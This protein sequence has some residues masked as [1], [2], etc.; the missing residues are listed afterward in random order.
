MAQS[1]GNALH[2]EYVIQ[3][4]NMG[5]AMTDFEDEVLRLLKQILS[6]LR[7]AQKK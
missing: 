3:R 5:I 4:L 1:V 2:V 7:K 6:T